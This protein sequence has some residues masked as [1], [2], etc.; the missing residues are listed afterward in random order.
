MKNL[1]KRVGAMALA[2]MV[3]AGGVALSGGK[4]SASGL[5]F[6]GNLYEHEIYKGSLK[7]L[8]P[9]AKAD[10]EYIDYF[11]KEEGYRVMA[12]SDNDRAMNQYVKEKFINRGLKNRLSEVPMGF[13]EKDLCLN[14]LKDQKPKIVKVRFDKA[15]LI[16]KKK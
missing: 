2:S 7:D 5:S 14:Y 3:V 1:H 6:F 15:I 4:A 12:V 9:A 11:L 10:Y 8:D 16:V 13:S